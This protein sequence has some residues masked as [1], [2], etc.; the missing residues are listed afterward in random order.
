[1][2]CSECNQDFD[3]NDSRSMPKA[4]LILGRN[5]SG[6]IKEPHPL[7]PSCVLVDPTTSEKKVWIT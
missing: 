6:E 4:F 5:S 7:C 2:K 1:M 3:E